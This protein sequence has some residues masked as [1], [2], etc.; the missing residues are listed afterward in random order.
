M[1]RSFYDFTLGG[2]APDVAPSPGIALQEGASAYRHPY[3]QTKFWQGMTLTV[4]RP[5][6]VSPPGGGAPQPFADPVSLGAFLV[7]P[8]PAGVQVRLRAVFERP[9]AS[10]G[11]PVTH[12][13]HHGPHLPPVGP[14]TGTWAVGVLLKSGTAADVK[15]DVRCAATCQFRPTGIRLNAP[16]SG[17]N[18]A[19]VDHR[20]Y[21]DLSPWSSPPVPFVLEIEL[22]RRPTAPPMN[23]RARL[24]IGEVTDHFEFAFT[25]FA[26]GQ[27]I[28]AAGVS[29]AIVN[30]DGLAMVRVRS[31]EVLVLP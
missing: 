19:E 4:V 21:A 3:T 29:V 30:G 16:G 23:A 1:S 6:T 24:A 15:A 18:H 14:G 5:A 22:D 2:Y 7:D 20:S 27:A 11:A 25:G 13:P 12:P 8:I 31:F 28:D 9:Y 10:F 26:A 17:V